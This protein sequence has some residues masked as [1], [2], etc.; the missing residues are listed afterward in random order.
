MDICLTD[1]SKKDKNMSAQDQIGCGFRQP[2]PLK[3]SPLVAGKL[4]LNEL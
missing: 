4:E 3:I 2:D 1:W